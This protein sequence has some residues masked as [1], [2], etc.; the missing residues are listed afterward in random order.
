MINLTTAETLFLQE[1][2]RSCEATT[3]F[4]QFGTQ[5]CSDP[6]CKNICETM[7]REHQQQM[8]RFSSFIN[9]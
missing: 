5:I 3:K 2:M 8:Q 6:R 7:V 9:S 1:H 4:L